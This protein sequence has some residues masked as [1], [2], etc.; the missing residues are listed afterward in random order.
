MVEQFAE[1]IV[2]AA[3]EEQASAVRWLAPLQESALRLLDAP[4]V[5]GV[6]MP[7]PERSSHVA[8]ALNLLDKTADAFAAVLNERRAAIEESNNRLRGVIGHPHLAS[9]ATKRE[10]DR[11]RKIQVTP[12]T[13]DV[14]GCY[15]LV[16]GAKR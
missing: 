12:Y 11:E 5:P 2:L 15:V 16:P 3:F 8:W 13:P 14:L 10:R 4:L 6:N 7:N 9:P 1:E